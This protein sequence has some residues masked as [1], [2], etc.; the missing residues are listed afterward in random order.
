MASRFTRNIR[1]LLVTGMAVAM[2]LAYADDTIKIGVI[3]EMSGPFAEFGKQMEAGIKIYQKQ[4]GESVAGK[5]VEVIY[6]DVGGPNPDVAKRLAQ[7]LLVRD[8]VQVLAGFGFTPNALSVAPIA[9]QAKVPMVVMNAAAAELT[10]KSPYMVRTSFTY[11]DV[12]PP[13]AQWAVKQGS[14]KAYVIVADYAPGHDAEAAFLGAYKKAGGE[15]VGNVRVPMVTVDFSPYIQRI[16]DAKPD[17]VF[18]FVNAGSVAPA[19]IKEFREKGLPEAGIKL[20]GTGDIVDEAIIDVIGDR[21]LDIVTV[22]PY[23]MHH[24]SELNAKYVRDFKTLR[25]ANARPTI[26]SVSAYDGMAAIYAALKKTGGKADGSSLIEALKGL[27][28]ESPRGMIG[29]S[30]QTRDIV[31]DEYIR[32]VGKVQGVLA[33]E[34]IETWKAAH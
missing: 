22:Y 21:A 25:G 27:Q 13:I 28:I 23:S 4:F 31:Q 29:I 24:K 34:E 11:P 30:A 10:A 2:P 16:K 7:E 5:R 19:F 14:K 3:A 8:K 20:I 12:V 15:I 18:A 26:M 1:R 32:R 33:N 17:V 6:R 9:T